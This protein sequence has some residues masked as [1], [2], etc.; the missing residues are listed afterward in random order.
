MREKNPISRQVRYYITKNHTRSIIE[1][2][3]K[4]VTPGESERM[5]QKR[6]VLSN[7]TNAY[8]IFI[9]SPHNQNFERNLIKETE[10]YHIT[11]QLL[12]WHHPTTFSKSFHQNKQRL[13]KGLHGRFRL[14]SLRDSPICSAQISLV[15]HFRDVHPAIIKK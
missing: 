5:Q 9:I 15:C 3:K 6:S 13:E 2:Y 8:I 1:K 12:N 7:T 10:I 14:L 11:A 4:R